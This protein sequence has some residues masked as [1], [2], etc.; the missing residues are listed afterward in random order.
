MIIPFFRRKACPNAIFRIKQFIPEE[1]CL[2][3]QGCCRFKETFGI[4]LPCVL[5]EEEDILKNNSLPC[6]QNKKVIPVFSEKE[7]IFFCPL[8]NRKEN[9]CVIYRERFFDCQLY[10]FVINRRQKKVYLS[11]DLNCDFI[12]DKFKGA[13]FEKYVKY[14]LGLL[15]SQVYKNILRSNPQIIQIYPEVIDLAEI[16]A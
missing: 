11:V 9:K 2:K 14:L 6:A 12:K 13:S 4:W 1:V 10:P 8:L 15:N 7:S 16:K 5:N 3:C